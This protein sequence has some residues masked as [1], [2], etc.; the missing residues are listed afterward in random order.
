MSDTEEQKVCIVCATFE[1][2][3]WRKS[4]CRNCFHSLEEHSE[5]LLAA[6]ADA[7][8]KEKNAGKTNEALS[9]SSKPKDNSIS[10]GKDVQSK[11]ISKESNG[12]KDASSSKD[13]KSKLGSGK[14]V[15][16][17]AGREVAKPG[18]KGSS[19]VAMIGG[20]SK[21]IT[22]TSS[23]TQSS[24]SS[25]LKTS[26]KTS[27]S[28]T[29]SSTSA[30][31][32]TSTAT[33]TVT[34]TASAQ[35]PSSSL[36]KNVASKFESKA[37]TTTP[38]DKPPVKTSASVSSLT[39]K[40]SGDSK[41]DSKSGSPP[42]TID[43]K[44]SDSSKKTDSKSPIK[45]E[46]SKS[47]DAAVSTLKSS[48]LDSKTNGSKT[49]E[50]TK[51]ETKDSKLG[52]DLKEKKTASILSKFEESKS[53]ANR[54]KSAAPFGKDLLKSKKDIG[55]K[56]SSTSLEVN[57]DSKTKDSPPKTK[58]SPPKTTGSSA[59]EK[60]KTIPPSKTPAGKINDDK[61]KKNGEELTGKL[62]G[63]ELG[64]S[65]ASTSPRQDAKGSS[66][67]ARSPKDPDP[68]DS[69]NV[70]KVGHLAKAAGK[71]TDSKAGEPGSSAESSKT[72]DD[73]KDKSSSKLDTSAK[74]SAQLDGDKPSHYGDRGK[75][76]TPEENGKRTESTASAASKPS[77]TSTSSSSKSSNL[78][79]DSKS[80]LKTVDSK[81]KDLKLDTSKD[82]KSYNSPLGKFKALEKTKDKP[83]D[84]VVPATTPTSS[85]TSVENGTRE[86]SK[87]K[88]LPEATSG[89][90]NL[91]KKLTAELEEKEKRL[92]DLMERLNKMEEQVKEM[93]KEKQTRRG[94]IQDQK[95][96]M[97]KLLKDLK[98]QLSKMETQCSK[99]EK[100]NQSLLDKLHAQEASVKRDQSLRGKNIDNTVLEEDLEAAEKEL[101]EVKE[102]N[103]ELHSQIMEM[104]NEMDEM[105]DHFRENEHDEF[106]EL[107]KELDMTAKNCR[108]LQFK[109]RKAERR[110][111]QI[112][113]DRIH[114]E[115]KL[116]QLQDQFDSQDAK[117]H[118]RVL[119]EE[120]RMAKEVSVR[121]HDEL[122]IV[123]DKR[124]KALEENRHLTELLEHTDKRQFRMEM[125]IDKLRDIV[126]DLR[127]QLKEA[128]SGN[129]NNKESTPER[130][131]P[132]IGTIG[133]QGSKEYDVSQ[134]MRDLCDS[135]EREN[136]LKDQLKFT[137]EEAKMMRRRVADMDEENESLRLQ[138]QK[139]SE[140]ATKHK[141]KEKETQRELEE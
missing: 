45:K 42:K 10:S 41:A 27:T 140:K 77:S 1:P 48:N 136:D 3:A 81:P 22:T 21:I 23:T 110:N 116:R 120:L 49:K 105:Y 75:E 85:K 128:K 125:E 96:E 14:E 4:L 39:S 26:P 65:S 9:D 2:Q 8:A 86:I 118:I 94:S 73:V 109:L 13:I 138:L 68:T 50:E 137:E 97:E 131:I 16:K 12:E 84:K 139:M 24:S 19:T 5:E 130:K 87:E 92:S 30:T 112:E 46:D 35:K 7:V 33:T 89:D 115:E 82:S 34:S 40:L 6:E 51:P 126:S 119:E 55:K 129:N 66:T 36:A 83:A 141:R 53:S 107:Q 71:V 59:N 25:S 63:G 29:T 124:N 20:R 44:S 64:Q 114:Y 76:K 52:L 43:N 11:P 102:E 122:D 67:G 135:M 132:P 38:K 62:K 100:D 70:N 69:A 134:L 117:N 91:T 61:S 90:D 17:D 95:E 31:S 103:K 106:R 72:T 74:L 78:A 111:D 88:S 121:L 101:E 18:L 93:E 99:L 108:I 113:E 80:G 37:A 104:K 127:Q 28:S 57:D 123:E 79:S 58:A 60:D 133:K 15:P 32:S 47:S 98:G 56:D 54:L